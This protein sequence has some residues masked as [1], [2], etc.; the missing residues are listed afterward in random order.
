MLYSCPI[1]EREDKD[2]N[3][4][5]MRKISLLIEKARISKEHEVLD[6]G[7]G[8]GCVAIE[9]VKRTGCKF[10]GITLSEEQLKYAEMKVKEAGF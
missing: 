6:F 1:F 3:V 2:L 4:A 8:W 7:C 10:A 9:A 5:Q